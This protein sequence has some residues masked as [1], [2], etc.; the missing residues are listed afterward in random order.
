M[1]YSIII[2]TY[3]RVD[4]V[5]DV[6]DSIVKY[7]VPFI[8]K[9]DLE[10][11][12]VSNGCTDKTVEYV[13]NLNKEKKIFKTV[14]YDKPLGYARAV[15]L[16]IKVS[17]GDYIV[18][19]NNDCV[20]QDHHWL[21]CLEEPFLRFKNVGLT[22]PLGHIRSN[23]P[24][25]IFFCVMIKREV[26][27]RIG[28]LSEEYG[29]GGGEDTEYCIKA[30]LEG[31]TNYMVPLFSGNALSKNRKIFFPIYHL[32]G[33]T[34]ETLTDNKETYERNNKRLLRLFGIP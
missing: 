31:Y 24:W 18:L 17:K 23:I 3:N 29:M 6:L 26:I 32:G 9:N 15:N 21:D 14:Y 27:E 12:V 22:G 11:I 10:I 16:G 33:Q 30:Y 5:K 20:I 7:S 19:L 1:K 8:E 13:Y 28:L 2:P 34:T 4:L 25:L